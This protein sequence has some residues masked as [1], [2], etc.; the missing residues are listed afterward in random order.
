MRLR[1]LGESSA[2][3]NLPF[4]SSRQ[5]SS[6]ETFGE[7]D[8]PFRAGCPGNGADKHRLYPGHQAAVENRTV[9]V[10]ETARRPKPPTG[11]P[12][13]S[14]VG[15]INVNAARQRDDRAHTSGALLL[16]MLFPPSSTRKP[17]ES[18]AGRWI[19]HRRFLNSDGRRLEYL[20]MC[21]F[22]SMVP[23]RWW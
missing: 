13:S 14:Q 4:G 20:T 11:L 9:V 3:K 18:T 1:L 6:C 2:E 5:P 17:Q 7:R 10:A 16:A 19:Q 12:C 21:S 22:R 15:I 8:R 23:V